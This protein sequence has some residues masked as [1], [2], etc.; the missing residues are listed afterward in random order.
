MKRTNVSTVES[1]CTICRQN[2]G[3]INLANYLIWENDS[4]LVRHHSAPYPLVGWLLLQPKR[5]VQGIAYFTTK[6]VHEYSVLA[7]FISL[8]L[9][10]SL[11]V[12]VVYTI[13]FG[14]SM[15]HMHQ[16][17]I[18]RNLEMSPEFL[19]FGIADLYRGTLNGSFKSKDSSDVYK[20]VTKL[21]K[22]FKSANI[23]GKLFE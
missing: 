6:E 5:H 11:N 12:P 4:W 7:R 10:R 1:V 9:Q 17:F 3:D 20:L 23:S 19:G 16:H 13:A 18:P 21:R 8:S 22:A 15:P 14:E 2:S